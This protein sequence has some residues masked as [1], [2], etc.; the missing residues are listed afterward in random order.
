[1]K[2]AQIA[3]VIERVPPKKYGGTERVVHALTEE[4][5]KRGHDVTLF[6]TADSQTDAKL[7]SVVEHSARNET[8]AN[9]YENSLLTLANLG[10]SYSLQDEFDIIHDHNAPVSL[11]LAVSAKT[12]IVMTLHNAFDKYAS[13]LYEK[14]HNSFN[15]YLTPISNAQRKN[16][17]S[18]NYTETVYHGLNM[19]HYP[20]SA[21]H[22]GYLL[23]VGRI[24]PKKGLHH[25]ITVAERLNLPLL[26]VAKLESFNMTYFKS[27]IEPRLN[28]QIRW[29]GEV[30]ERQRN[31]LMSKAFCM[32][33]PVTWP[34]PFG[35]VL[36]EAL[37]NGC[38]VVAFN[39][40]S[41]AEIIE[42]KKT[43]FVVE[44]VDGMTQMVKKVFKINRAYCRDYALHDFGAER[45]AGEYE[46]IYEKILLKRLTYFQRI[47][48]A[49]EER[50]AQVLEKYLE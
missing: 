44:G 3:P 25:A 46:K 24:S 48:H 11:P 13:P 37:A 7:I 39:N 9:A 18:L 35:L 14:L 1:M 17:P 32:L 15:P 49:K 5:V 10:L 30:D 50:T 38:P 28:S 12:P 8:K 27:K 40:G 34:E 42:D 33:H 16:G 43:G 36:I 22:N 21:N 41:I 19:E 4:L 26:I 6:A 20:F 45:M 47:Y 23:F 2:I 29:L 31:K